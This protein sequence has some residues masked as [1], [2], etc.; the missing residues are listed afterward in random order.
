MI[1]KVVIVG[2]RRGGVL[3]PK[4]E[5]Q[6][7]LGRCGRGC[8]GKAVCVSPLMDSAHAYDCLEGNPDPVRSVMDE[9]LHVSFHVLPEICRLGHMGKAEYEDWFS[10]TL[11]FSQGGRFGWGELCDTLLEQGAV[12][13]DEETGLS[14]TQ[15]GRISS[16]LYYPMEDVNKVLGK[17]QIAKGLGIPFDE[18][19]VSWACAIENV[20]WNGDPPPEYEDYVSETR[21]NG[22]W[23]HY[24]EGMDAFALF[25]IFNRMSPKWLRGRIKSHMEGFRRLFSLAYSLAETEGMADFMLL[26]KRWEPCIGKR[27]PVRHWEAVEGDPDASWASI[28]RNL[29]HA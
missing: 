3:V 20:A 14:P 17:L 13:G 2:T 15:T 9:P 26:L 1:D 10:R 4:N 25:C 5:M 21:R 12:V 22:C 19:T 23:F 18:T 11:A 16:R 28:R 6:Q 27:I 24:G 8:D 29:L 7:M